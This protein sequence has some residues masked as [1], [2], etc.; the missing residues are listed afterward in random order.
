MH[1]PCSKIRERRMCCSVNI[2]IAAITSGERNAGSSRVFIARGSISCPRA[3]H[4]WNTR[5]AKGVMETR[6]ADLGVS[7][8]DKMCATY[9]R[10]LLP[11]C[12]GRSAHPLPKF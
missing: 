6:E 4:R 1:P 10:K 7:Y 8:G 12:V 3:F 9:D 11:H 2:V 5:A